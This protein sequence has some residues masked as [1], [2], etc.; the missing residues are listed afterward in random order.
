MRRSIITVFAAVMVLLSAVVQGLAQEQSRTIGILALGNPNPAR[1]L[2]EF[3]AALAELGYVEGQNVK[4]EIRSAEGHAA[5]LEPMARELVGLKVDVLVTYQTPAATAAKAATTALPIVM[6][7]VADPVG[8]GLVRSLAH[9]GGNIT[10]IS[11]ATSE[12]VVKNLELAKDLVPSAHRIAVLTNEPDPFHKILIAHVKTAAQQLN[13]QTKIVLARAGDDFDRH[14]KDTKAWGADAA[15]V[16]PSLPLHDIA[17]AA[18]KNR[19]PALC[20]NSA[21]TQAGGLISYSA[22]LSSVH[23]EAAIIVDK[24]LKGRKPADLP[25]QLTT[26]FRLVINAKAAK[27]IGLELSPLLIARADEIIE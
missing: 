27:A 24:V 10:G 2:K 5:R 22:D 13:V 15:L 14:L 19:L 8:S 21:Y 3:R 4:L 17:G 20:P 1:F 18:I 7:S 6:A 12:L 26:K 25:V 11:G 16:Q 23:R 9:P